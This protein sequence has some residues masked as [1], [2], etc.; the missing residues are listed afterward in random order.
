[1][2]Q[3]LAAGA[4]SG[5]AASAE[6]EL[7][8]LRSEGTFVEKPFV[9]KKRSFRFPPVETMGQRVVDIK[10]M[11]HG[12]GG[13]QLFRDVDLTINKGERI[14]IIGPNGGWVCVGCVWGRGVG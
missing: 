11:S 1:M 6:K 10:S 9:P 13:Q 3:R 5:R 14:A 7:E 4:N 12:Y 8:R 2:I